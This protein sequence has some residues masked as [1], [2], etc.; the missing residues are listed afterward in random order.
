ML[1]VWL[2]DT[3]THTHTHTLTLTHIDTD[4]AGM[5]IQILCVAVT[6]TRTHLLYS[7][8]RHTLS[9]H[10]RTH[11]LLL[12]APL[13]VEPLYS[14]SQTVTVTVLCPTTVPTYPTQPLSLPRFASSPWISLLHS[15]PPL[16]SIHHPAPITHPS[17]L[18]FRSPSLP[19]RPSQ[20][21]QLANQPP[22]V[23]RSTLVSSYCHATHTHTA[24]RDRAKGT[25]LQ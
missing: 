7:K 8:D 1:C 4:T 3:H 25:Y 16:T 15:T 20:P 23:G 14:N 18:A 11:T 13:L 17:A 22:F 24:D 5:G 9:M 10:K 19:P 6:F 2:T 21:L 12:K